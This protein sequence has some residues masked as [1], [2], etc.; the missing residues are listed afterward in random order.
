[1][2]ERASCSSHFETVVTNPKS[3][4]HDMSRDESTSD[5]SNNNSNNTGQTTVEDE[6]VVPEKRKGLPH[7]RKLGIA[8][9]FVM[10]L[11]LA[12]MLRGGGTRQHLRADDPE[13]RSRVEF[14]K[15]QTGTQ[16]NRER[17]DVEFENMKAAPAIT[18]EMNSGVTRDPSFDREISGL[19]L[20]EE[21]H[22]RRSSRDR[23]VPLNPDLPDARIQ[24]ILQD[25]QDAA[26]W[27]QKARKE[28]V[29][30]FVHNATAAG[31]R[32]KID[33]NLNVIDARRL[34]DSTG[35]PRPMSTSTSSSS[36]EPSGASEGSGGVAH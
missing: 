25:E 33:K 29:D 31:Y 21:P 15:R 13:F 23:L 22:H 35:R 19:P 12:F 11:L 16:L 5:N 28:F 27:E 24:Y 4:W 6:Q 30:D 34:P 32:V 14:Y 8:L 3:G 2:R 1:M 26:E 7:R 10:M 18:R 36:G 20:A 17:I 9:L